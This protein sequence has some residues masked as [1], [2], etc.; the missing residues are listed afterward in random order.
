M[1]RCPKKAVADRDD[2]YTIS[3]K[4]VPDALSLTYITNTF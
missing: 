2:L 4:E 1:E 3:P